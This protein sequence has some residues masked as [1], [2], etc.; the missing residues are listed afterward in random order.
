MSGEYIFDINYLKASI[1]QL[2]NEIYRIVSNLNLISGNMYANLFTRL[3][4]IQEDLRDILEGR[5]VQGK[6]L[7]VIECERLSSDLSAM[8]G[9]KNASL[10]EIGRHLELFTP[11]GFAVTTAAYKRFMEYNN[12]WPQIRILYQEQDFYRKNAAALYDG[13]I[14][15]LFAAARVPPDLEAAIEKALHSLAKK[16]NC[17]Y[18]FA[19][20]SSAYGEDEEGKSYAGQFLS[21]LNCPLNQV[22]PAYVRV[23]SSRFKYSA[24]VYDESN[25]L[26]ESA[27]PMAVG[28]QPMIP[29]RAAGVIYTVDVSGDFIDCMIVAASYG[30]GASV[31][32]GS[33]NA[34]YFRV[35]RLD[36]TN[37]QD[38]RIGKKEYKLVANIGGGL[39][40]VPV[41]N[42][43]QMQECLSII[44]ILELS[45]KALL[46]ERYFK[47]ALDIEWC[48]DE[49]GILF[50]LQCRPLM[51][52]RKKTIDT[53][54]LRDLLA[55]KPIILRDQGQVAQRGIAAGKVWH[56]KEDDDPASFPV[57]A[58]AV[59]EH[60]TPRLASIIRRASAIV[61]DAGSSTGHMATVAREYGVPMIVNTS[62][63]TR[64]LENGAEITVDAEENIIY[65][66]IIKELM[67]YEVKSEDVFRD[68]AEYKILKR[69]LRKISPLSLLDPKDPDFTVR[70]CR[71]YHDI[72]RFCHEKAIKELTD[73][74]ISSRRF[75]GVKSKKIKL[76]IPLGLYVIDLGGGL[77]ESLGG[78]RIESVDQIQSKPMKALLKGLT[79][80]G[81]WSTQAMQFGLDDFISSITRYSPMDGMNEYQ[82]Q[83]LAVIS[84]CY[85]NINLR[86]G[87]HFNVI[88]TY[89]SENADDN[90]IYFRFVGGVTE[91]ERRHLRAILLKKILENSDFKVTVSGDLVVARLKC[92]EASKILAI[93]EMLG[94]LIGF[95]RQLDTQMRSEE[96][97]E[98][99]LNAFMQLQ[100]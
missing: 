52:P 63:A 100:K 72:I 78:D 48:L 62:N 1:D 5:R 4:A 83:N 39:K 14:D 38:M 6:D 37:I 97:I 49:K 88:D 66:G 67:E 32:S 75:R 91:S 61:T 95:S 21:V 50:I 25:A 2:T 35:S 60:P 15:E 43:L 94:R 81:I 71:T 22:L 54:D 80:P 69:L 20:R 7:L 74:N 34:D 85:A 29:A 33:V 90:Y 51:V 70:N 40:H 36:P 55:D 31:V 26:S 68:L 93:L 96:A 17:E 27:L 87:Y 79:A 12:L 23:L 24:L 45:E 77:A 73:L 47:R 30:I 56:V 46:M 13:K 99:Y 53:T 59:T 65:R 92:W 28:I 11:G 98:T 64:Q 82:G 41:A 19:V 44:D 18:G 86:L 76:P 3:I 10:A 9:E 58:I 84:D 42:D 8:A 89:I 57:G 16:T